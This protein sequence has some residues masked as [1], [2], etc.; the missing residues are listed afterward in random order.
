MPVRLAAP[1]QQPINVVAQPLP[2]APQQN[3]QQIYAVNQPGAQV[4]MYAPPLQA[5]QP[6]HVQHAVQAP[7][8]S[9]Y[10]AQPQPQP[11]PQQEYATAYNPQQQVA[12]AY[13]QFPQ[14]QQQQQQQQQ[15]AYPPQYQ[16]QQQPVYPPPQ[17]A[18][19][20]RQPAY[21]Q[22]QVFAPPPNQPYAPPPPQQVYP[23]QNQAYD[24]AQ[25][26][27]PTV[28]HYPEIQK[29][30]DRKLGQGPAPARPDASDGA[31]APPPPV[32]ATAAALIGE[33]SKNSKAADENLLA[34]SALLNSLGPE[35][36][37]RMLCFGTNAKETLCVRA[38][39]LSW[40]SR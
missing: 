20:Q 29:Q 32:S 26:A 39:L 6:L 21:Q 1:A 12:G 19:P 23:Q 37:Q 28:P 8:Q 13:L 33:V 40:L 31:T 38:R 25:Q 35:E 9:G 36:P 3:Q 24:P 2:P 5:T 17:P 30:P 34:M 22:Q 18:Y 4:P 16:Q 11:Q 10:L 14:Q 7:R 15:P 27:Y